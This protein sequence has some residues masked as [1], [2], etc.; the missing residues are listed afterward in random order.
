[1]TFEWHEGA[2][3]FRVFIFIFLFKT[4]GKKNHLNENGLCHCYGIFS[5][6]TILKVT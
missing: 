5:E 2:T 6:S 4:N 3:V 1:M